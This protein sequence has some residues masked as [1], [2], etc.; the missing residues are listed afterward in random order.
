V[1]RGH[2]GKLSVRRTE[3]GRQSYVLWVPGRTPR[4]HRAT[5]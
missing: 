5:G 2:N 3:D 4:A 1:V